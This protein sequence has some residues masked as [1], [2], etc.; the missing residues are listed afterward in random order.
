MQEFSFSKVK[1]HDAEHETDFIEQMQ[2]VCTAHA[3]AGLG[4]GVFCQLRTDWTTQ[5]VVYALR[6]TLRYIGYGY[7]NDMIF[8]NLGKLVYNIFDSMSANQ[9]IQALIRE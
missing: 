8:Y 7:N 4:V 1:Q 9:S 6:Q 3:Q 2:K 5:G